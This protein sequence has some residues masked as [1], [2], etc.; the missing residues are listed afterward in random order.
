MN[1]S[2]VLTVIAATAAVMLGINAYAEDNSAQMTALQ[3]RAE[4]IQ[5]QMTEAK[6]QCGANLAGQMKSLTASIENLVKQRVQLGAQI[7]QLEAQVEE[8]KSNAVASCGRR[9]K[10]Y[11]EELANIKQQMAGLAA[12]SAETAPKADAA[13]AKNAPVQATGQ[14]APPKP[15]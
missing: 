3:Q 4:L 1:K 6:Q 8:L 7:T 13:A 5:S 11:E 12:K 14:A 15:R 10:Q 2:L 9:M